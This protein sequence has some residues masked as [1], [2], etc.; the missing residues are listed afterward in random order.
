VRPPA[1]V[2]LA[3]QSL[4]GLVVV[5][6]T[7]GA[8]SVLSYRNPYYTT[9]HVIVGA[10]TLAVSFGLTWWSFRGRIEQAGRACP[11]GRHFDSRLCPVVMTNRGFSFSQ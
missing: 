8:A 5:Q 1:V 6:I 4:V 7:L 3:A 10:L 2:K 9:A 11:R